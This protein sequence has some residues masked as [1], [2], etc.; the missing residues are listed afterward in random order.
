MVPIT[1]LLILRSQLLFTVKAFFLFLSL[2]LQTLLFYHLETIHLFVPNQS[3]G[4]KK[5]SSVPKKRRKQ[6]TRHI[7]TYIYY[8]LRPSF[9][10]ESHTF[11]TFLSGD[12]CRFLQE[13]QKLNMQIFRFKVV[14]RGH[15]WRTLLW[16]QLFS[17]C[18]FYKQT[19]TLLC[20][21]LFLSRLKI[22]RTSCLVNLCE[23][24]FLLALG[25]QLSI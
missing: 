7:P 23:T 15:L 16:G 21:F 25:I 20:F 10:T 2:A 5:T 4:V 19:L 24:S 1:F 6:W 18:P 14:W 13:K 8:I 12:P 17:K 11:H 3:D 22:W 9:T